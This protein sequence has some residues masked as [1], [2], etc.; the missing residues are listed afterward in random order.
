MSR[1]LADVRMPYSDLS[2]LFQALDGNAVVRLGGLPEF[3]EVVAIH[4]DWEYRCLVVRFESDA[5]A[6]VPEG[7]P[8]PRLA[9]DFGTGP[10]SDRV[11]ELSLENRRLRAENAELTYLLGDRVLD[12]DLASRAVAMEREACA[13]LAEAMP[14]EDWEMDDGRGDRIAKAIRERAT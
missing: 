14:F 9:V 1:R 3:A 10:A 5:F 8:M 2:R 6:E 12:S 11:E 13:K 4:D 7:E